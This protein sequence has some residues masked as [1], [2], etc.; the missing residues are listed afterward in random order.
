MAILES[1]ALK[2]FRLLSAR[3]LVPVIPVSLRLF[4]EMEGDAVNY[5]CDQLASLNAAVVE[6]CSTCLSLFVSLAP[7]FCVLLRP[8]LSRV[9]LLRKTSQ[10]HFSH[11]HHS[12]F[13]GRRRPVL[14]P[15]CCC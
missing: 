10:T 12:F 1:D 14:D 7:V 2:A 4:S 9:R 3:P 11:R 15:V 6:V 8:R 5:E 13:L